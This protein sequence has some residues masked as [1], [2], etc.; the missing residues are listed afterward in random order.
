MSY[1][2]L[3][4]RE[5]GDALPALQGTAPPSPVPARRGWVNGYLRD[6]DGVESNPELG[7]VD[8][9]FGVGEVLTGDRVRGPIAFAVPAGARGLVLL[10]TRREPTGLT[11]RPPS[12]WL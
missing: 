6:G 3:Q 5:E 11:A 8:G 12:A 7:G 9:Q 10:D 2:A 4:P 1:D